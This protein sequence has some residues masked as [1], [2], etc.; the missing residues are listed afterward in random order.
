VKAAGFNAVRIPVSWDCC[1]SNGVIDT[2]W[3]ARVK[4]VVDYRYNNNLD[5]YD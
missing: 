5:D 3:M 1:C 4:I 2:N